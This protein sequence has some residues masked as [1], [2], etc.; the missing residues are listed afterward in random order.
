MKTIVRALFAGLGLLMSLASPAVPSAT[1]VD[2]K[3]LSDQSQGKNWL[4]YGRNFYEQRYSPLTQVNTDSARRLGLEWSMALP[5]DHSLLSTPLVVDGV[6]Y[7]TGSWSVARAVDAKT[8][9]LLWE[10]DPKAIEHAGERLRNM[11]D[12]SR[13]LAYWKGVVVIATVDG[14]L[15]ALDAKTGK[16]RWSTQTTDPGKP[17]YISGHPKVFRGLVFVGNGGT[18]HGAARGYVSAYHI[19]TG[20]LAWRWYVVPGNP[21]DGFEDPSQE[22]AARTWTGEW[23]KF[24]GGGN[25]WNGITY[26]PEFNQVLFGT[27]NGSPW[28]RKV[29]SPGGGDNLFLCSVVAL[30]A[31]TGKYKWH[32][33]TTPGETWDYNSSMDIVLADLDL[34]GKKVKAALHAPK[35]GFFYVLNRA[36][37]KLLTAEKFAQANWATGIDPKTGRPIEAPGARYED[38]E[39][40]IYPS[41]FGAHSW[42]AMSYSPR[43]G[44]VYIPKQEMPALYNDKEVRMVDWR[45]PYFNFDPGV[46]VGFGDDVPRN[47]AH[48]SLLAW[49]PVKQSKA[50][51]VPQQEFLNAGTMVTAGDV[52]FQGGVTGEFAAYDARN[53]TKL[54]SVNVG[55][56]ISAPPIT[57]EVGGKQYVSLLVGFGGA[58]SSVAGGSAMAQFGWSYGAQTRQL[59]TFALDAKAPMPKV[60]DPLI[61]KPLVPPDVKPDAKL[62]DRGRDLY[63]GQCVWCHGSGAV[64]G[65]YAP[66]LRASPIPLSFDAFKAV[67]V[68]G[69]KVQPY[70]MP[71]FSDLRDEDLNALQ[72]FIRQRAE[73]G[74]KETDKAA[75]D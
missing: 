41:P 68:G 65:G 13:G 54:W 50:W 57:Y 30:D 36:N 8:G 6:L 69:A 9:K 10:F 73:I 7:F 17:L 39:E 38:G 58:G 56:G 21:A 26:D 66:D 42:H 70:G 67:V 27:G 51:E 11:W 61:P 71:K 25:V 23:W 40:L 29:R 62:A 35:N 48:S 28:N 63:V 52:V 32:Y 74:T 37:G 4:A 53:G 24:G 47:V 59:Y 45:S 44:F 22:M 46:G 75:A 20:K 16:M 12:S 19:T 49:D 60:G 31:D 3:A 18:E 33:Q 72:N 5:R 55:S 2:A 1:V 34:N 14:R 43:T 64:S 15:I